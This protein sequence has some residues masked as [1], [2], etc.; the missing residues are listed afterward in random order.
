MSRRL[1]KII[2]VL[3]G[4]LLLITIVP[5]TILYRETIASLHPDRLPI[6]KTPADFDMDYESI[7][8]TTDDGIELQGW[9][10]PSRNGAAIIAQHGYI[11]NRTVMLNIAS[12]L[13]KH[14]YG[15]IMV[16]LRAHG[17]SGGELTTFGKLEQLDVD[18]AYQYLLTREDVDPDKIGAFGNSLGGATLIMYASRNKNIKA[19]ASQ[20]AFAEIKGSLAMKIKEHTGVPPLPIAID[21][22]VFFSE[23]HTGF[24][25]EEIRVIDYIDDLSPRPIFLMHGGEDQDSPPDSGH[26]LYNAA[27]EPRELWYEPNQGHVL[28]DESYPEEF[29]ERI[30]EFFDMYLLGQ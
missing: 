12:I 27:N 3:I 24:K 15:V 28:F 2:P 4:M 1:K 5:T 17:E 16:D 11:S 26:R 23:Q 10:V 19:I 29:E 6:D 25:A 18:A 9:Y 30:I 20:S 14:G 8:L 22:V 21:L 7:T 13:N